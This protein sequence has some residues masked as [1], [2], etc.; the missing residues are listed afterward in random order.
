MAGRR[1]IVKGSEIIEGF[2]GDEEYFVFYMVLNGE[3]VVLMWSLE[4]I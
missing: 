4:R 2:V 3:P 1:V